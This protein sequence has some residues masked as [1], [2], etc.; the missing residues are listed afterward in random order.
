[1]SDFLRCDVAQLTEAG[2][3]LDALGSAF[4]QAGNLADDA[5]SAVGHP[6]LGSRLQEFADGWK[7]RREDL[8]EDMTYLADMTHQ[9]ASTYKQVDDELAGAI[10]GAGS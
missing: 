1:V 2:N 8:L 3:Q 7:V 10:E 9:A 5:R 6:R 4:Q